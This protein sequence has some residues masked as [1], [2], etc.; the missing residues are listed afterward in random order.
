MNES[1]TVNKNLI[2]KRPKF[3]KVLLC[4]SSI[5]VFFMIVFI[6]L[7]IL[8]ADILGK[9]SF[10]NNMGRGAGISYMWVLLLVS[11]SFAIFASRFIN[12]FLSRKSRILS[13]IVLAV[14]I[15][16]GVLLIPASF[17]HIAH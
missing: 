3:L 4:I 12:T 9:F 15:L 6:F 17:T 7:L 1:K 11:I 8:G 5:W 16:L 2:D 14:F 10:Y 13:Y